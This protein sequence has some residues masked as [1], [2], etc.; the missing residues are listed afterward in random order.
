MSTLIWN[1]KKLAMVWFWGLLQLLAQLMTSQLNSNLKLKWPRAHLYFVQTDDASTVQLLLRTDRIIWKTLTR[2]RFSDFHLDE[3]KLVFEMVPVM[4]SAKSSN[5]CSVQYGA[6]HFFIRRF[7][8][9]FLLFG[10]ST[11]FIEQHS[12]VG[13]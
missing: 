13:L 2:I 7:S 1:L 4:L 11:Y 8:N 9:E 5:F 6:R 10:Y 3:K 12:T